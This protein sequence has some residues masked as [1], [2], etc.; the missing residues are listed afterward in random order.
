[1]PTLEKNED[2]RLPVLIDA[3]NSEAEEIANLTSSIEDQ[4]VAIEQDKI[5]KIDESVFAI[6]RILLTLS[7]AK[8]HRIEVATL[9]GIDDPEGGLSMLE[10]LHQ[11]EN[12]ADLYNAVTRLRAS[13]TSLSKLVRINRSILREALTQN[14]RHAAAVLGSITL[15]SPTYDTQGSASQIAKGTTIFSATA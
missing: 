14:E 1:M 2:I 10:R 7:E 4:R 13:A 12:S 11:Y 6:H 5:D 15:E 3:L 8:R 9:M